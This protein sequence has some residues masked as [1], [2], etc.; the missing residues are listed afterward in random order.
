MVVSGSPKRWDRWHSPSPNWQEKYHLYTTYILPSGGLYNP[1]HRL[2]EPETTIDIRLP[3][4]KLTWQW[5][6]NLLKMYFLLKMAL[7]TSRSFK[8]RQ[9]PSLPWWVVV[10]QSE[11][12]PKH[13]RRS[14]CPT[15]AGNGGGKRPTLGKRR[16]SCFQWE[17]IPLH[18]GNFSRRPPQKK[19]QVFFC[20][21]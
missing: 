9:V 13:Q 5:K 17:I 19:N 21:R 3:S 7:G 4:G 12:P 2:G 10:H 6:M 14:T 18:I 20:S 11:K 8:A 16:N 15:C 1:Y